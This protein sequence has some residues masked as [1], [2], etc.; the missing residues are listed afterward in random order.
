MRKDF[1]LKK[2]QQGHPIC[3]RKEERIL[4][5]Y[6]NPNATHAKQIV[7]WTR[8]GVPHFCSSD[9]KCTDN[10]EAKSKYDLFL[11]YVA[12]KQAIAVSKYPNSLGFHNVLSF[13]VPEGRED[14]LFGSRDKKDWDIH[15]IEVQK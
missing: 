13:S 4:V 10:I 1:D 2:M 6:Y 15:Y 14:E 12:V 7:Y 3:T 11:Y 5:F 8:D 9:G